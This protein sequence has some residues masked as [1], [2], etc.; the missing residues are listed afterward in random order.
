VVRTTTAKRAEAV[1]QQR[2]ISTALALGLLLAACDREAGSG[3]QAVPTKEAEPRDVSP[4][5][6]VAPVAPEAPADR[7]G[8]SPPALTQEAERGEKGARNLLLS[9]ARAIELREFGLAWALL[10]PAD[11]ARWSKTAFANMFDDLGKITVAVPGGTMGAAA[12]SS[13]YDAPITITANDKDG[14]PVRVE[15]KAVVRRVNDVPG[16]TEAQLRWHFETLMLDWT[17]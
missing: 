1:R 13:Y 9:F 7:P 16:A 8:L 3:N 10:S 11:K 14:R 2:L 15:G 12:G 5:T 17:H 4:I 6:P